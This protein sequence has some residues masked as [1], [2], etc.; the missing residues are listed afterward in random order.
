MATLTIN[1]TEYPF[2][3]TGRLKEIVKKADV[4]LERVGTSKNETRRFSYL[5]AKAATE[6]SGEDFSFRFEEF[7]SLVEPGMPEKAQKLAAQLTG[8]KA[9]KAKKE[10]AEGTEQ[11]DTEPDE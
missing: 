5:A 11:A 7:I 9:K 4:R 1:K 8:K 6:E 3:V 10:D 2:K